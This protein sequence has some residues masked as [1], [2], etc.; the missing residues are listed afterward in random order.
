VFDFFEQ[1]KLAPE[2]L[3]KV[4]QHQVGSWHASFDALDADRESSR[5]NAP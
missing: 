5:G 4:S 3:R 1:E 2:F